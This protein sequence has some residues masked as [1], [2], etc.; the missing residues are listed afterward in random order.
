MITELPARDA[1]VSIWVNKGFIFL[2]SACLL[3]SCTPNE[4]SQSPSENEQEEVGEVE[5]VRESATAVELDASLLADT[6][7]VSQSLAQISSTTFAFQELFPFLYELLKNNPEELAQVEAFAE[8]AVSRPS[9]SQEEDLLDLIEERDE[10]II[11][12]LLPYFESME[13]DVWDQNYDELEKELSMMGIQ[14]TSAEGIF[15]GLGPRSLFTDNLKLKEKTPLIQYDAFTD[16][17]TRSMNGEYPYSD[18]EPYIK[19]VLLGEK[20][21]AE[22]TAKSYYQKIGQSFA[23]ALH[24]LTDVH[25]ITNE[26]GRVGG[27]HTEAYPYMVSLQSIREALPRFES[28]KFKVPLQRIVEFPSEMSS[29]PEHLHL[30]V[31]SWVN[32]EEEAKKRVEEHLSSGKD[33]PHYLPVEKGDGTTQYAVVYR[34]FEDADQAQKGLEKMQT[35]FNTGEM[36]FVSSEKSKLYQLGY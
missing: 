3:W 24:V 29:R 5:E 34:F 6:R 12:L 21:E 20:M 33:I 31:E 26:G 1:Y 28:S 16:A 10:Q 25:L 2:L 19:M 11:P 13:P 4:P 7:A 8:Q 14:M 32:S 17:Q 30:L 23:D 18:L 15:T 22:G 9:F 27:I 35:Q 36:I